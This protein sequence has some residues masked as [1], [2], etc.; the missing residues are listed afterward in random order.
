M[1]VQLKDNSVQQLYE[2]P[3]SGLMEKRLNF[4]IYYIEKKLIMVYYWLFYRILNIKLKI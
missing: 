1:L 2:Y 4:F 3:E